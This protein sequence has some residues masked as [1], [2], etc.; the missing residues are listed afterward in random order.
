MAAQM[1]RLGA[2]MIFNHEDWGMAAFE[3]KETRVASTARATY[4][5][6]PA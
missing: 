4:R 5:D 1:R 3:L 2:P 6:L